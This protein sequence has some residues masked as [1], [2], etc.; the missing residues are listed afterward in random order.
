MTTSTRR[1]VALTVLALLSGSASA[2]VPLDSLEVRDGLLYRPQAT[3]PYT[4]MVTTDGRE[5][6]EAKQGMRTGPWVWYHG[7]GQAAQ[8]VEYRSGERTRS[9][10]WFDN[11]QKSY[12]ATFQD[13]RP[14]GTTQ[15][16]SRDGVLKEEISYANGQRSGPH[17]V[18]DSA[19][20]LLYGASYQGDVLSG[21]VIWWYP[22]GT[23]RWETSYVSGERDGTW[24]QYAPDG[25]AG[26]TSVWSAGRL[27]SRTDP[28]EGH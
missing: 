18:F 28:H 4:G 21:S 5:T 9:V 15:E 13:G 10:S 6:G 16:W 19:G 12:E 1:V 11:G 26:M 3:Q 27:V 17:R 25:E 14:H 8:R 23:K 22:D 7:N 2:Q 24:T 20:L